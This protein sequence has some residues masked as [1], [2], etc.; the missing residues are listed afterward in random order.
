MD[1]R[2]MLAQRE[3]IALLM[4]AERSGISFE[5]IL[6]KRETKQLFSQGGTDRYDRLRYYYR[7][8]GNEEE[9][10]HRET[11]EEARTNKRL[12]AA[13]NKQKNIIHA[14]EKADRQKDVIAQRTADQLLDRNRAETFLKHWILYACRLP[15]LPQLRT[16]LPPA[17]Q[18]LGSHGRL[19]RKTRLITSVHSIF[20]SAQSRQ[21]NCR[22]FHMHSCFRKAEKKKPPQRLLK[23][24]ESRK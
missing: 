14:L 8:A 5:G 12:A 21:K 22:D 6:T 11:L 10:F 4:T 3:L 16:G 13:V 19:R 9:L 15:A 23:S 20:I 1:L 18:N 17:D 2:E 7:F 24:S